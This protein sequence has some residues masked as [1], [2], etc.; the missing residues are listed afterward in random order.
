MKKLPVIISIVASLAIGVGVGLAIGY[1]VF[2][3]KTTPNT[4]TSSAPSS[5]SESSNSSLL[6]TSSL[7]LVEN[8]TVTFK[9]Y[10]G[11]LLSEVVVEKGQTVTYNGPTPTRN[12]TNEATYTFKGWDASLENI[13]SDCI[14]VA[15]YNETLKPVTN[16]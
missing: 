8:C 10:D 15:Q 9:N 6:T 1:T 2:N 11:T 14:R 16:Y 3:T 13:T 7:P 4:S 5:S 12:E